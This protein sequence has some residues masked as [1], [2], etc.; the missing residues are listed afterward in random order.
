M[1]MVTNFIVTP[2][3]FLSGT[4]YSIDYSIERLPEPS[5]LPSLT[6]PLFWM[7]D[8]FRAGLTDHAEG[9]PVLGLAAL[10]LLDAALRW[11]ALVLPRRGW[12]LRS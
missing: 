9:T 12:R 1:A 3:A 10:A 7:I 8:A 6:N 4:F 11:G 2:L 5:R